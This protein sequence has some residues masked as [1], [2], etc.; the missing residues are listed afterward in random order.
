MGGSNTRA[1]HE[2]EHRRDLRRGRRLLDRAQLEARTR[3]P[4]HGCRPARAA[5]R[6]QPQNAAEADSRAGRPPTQRRPRTDGTAE[7]KRFVDEQ[8]PKVAALHATTAR[9]S[10]S[11]RT[12]TASSS[13]RP[14]TCTRSIASAAMDLGKHVYVQKPLC[15]SVAGSAAPRAEGE[16][17][18]KI[19]TQMGNQGHSSDEARTRLR[20]HRGRRDRR[21]Q[22]KSTSGRTGRS[23]TGRRAFRGRRRSPPTER[24]CRWNGTRRRDAARRARW[25]ATIRCPTSC[26]WDLF[27]GVAPHVEY[28]PVYH[29]F[30]WRGWVDWGQGALGDMGAH[31]ID[32]PFWALDLGCPTAIETISTPFNGV[33]YP[34]ATTTYYEFPARGDKPPVKLTWYDG[35]LLPPRPDELRRARSSNGDGRRAA[36]SAA[37][38]S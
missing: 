2:P 30:N 27:L 23:A 26:A 34:N 9:C 28:H 8:L 10:T 31:L 20:V 14:I 13:R 37:R 36:T 35:G 18:P 33:C 38:A 11:R 4:R 3:R 21:R 5:R 22:A 1:A 7:L 32:H 24:R 6:R 16:G 25:P 17:Q 15:W 19:V 29:P 12:S